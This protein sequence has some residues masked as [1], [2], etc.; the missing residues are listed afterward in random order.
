MNYDPIHIPTG[1]GPWEFACPAV[2]DAVMAA[3]GSW[4]SPQGDHTTILRNA[5]LSAKTL[6]LKL[7]I[8]AGNF[9]VTDSIVRT[10]E[11]F[12]N[13]GV[14]GEA[15]STRLIR[16]IAGQPGN[17][18]LFT[19][20]G[21]LEVDGSSTSS[22]SYYFTTPAV[23]GTDTVQ[24]NT[25][26]NLS[27]GEWL[28]FIDRTQPI[29]H[30][31]LSLSGTRAATF[32][33]KVQIQYVDVP[34]PFLFTIQSSVYDADAGTLTITT[35]LPGIN[36]GIGAKITLVSLSGTGDFDTLEGREFFTVD[37]T[38]GRTTTIVVGDLDAATAVT[39][40]TISYGVPTP[41]T[42][43]VFPKLEA[44]YAGTSTSPNL[45]STIVRRF[46]RSPENVTIDGIIFDYD[47]TA[48]PITTQSCIVWSAL[49][50]PKSR[51]CEFYGVGKGYN[52][53]NGTSDFS[54]SE[55]FFDQGGP[56]QYGISV[57][58][59]S[60]GGRIYDGS[61]AR[62][63][64]LTNTL[65]DVST[66][67]TTCAPSHIQ[68]QNV[69]AYS[70][71]L[72]PFTDHPGVRNLSWINCT[73]TGGAASAFSLRGVDERVIN[74][75]GYGNA[76]GADVS[77][78]VN[79]IIDGGLYV[80]NGVG[81]SILRC[82]NP[83]IINY[84][85]IRDSRKAHI[86]CEMSIP[87]SPFDVAYPGLF[88]EAEVSGVPYLADFVNIQ[89]N[90]NFAPVYG[91]DWRIKIRVA[92]RAPTFMVGRPSPITST[93]SAATYDTVTA[94]ATI[95]SS[96]PVVYRAGDI[97][98]LSAL[99]GTGDYALLNGQFPTRAPTSGNTTTIYAPGLNAL[100]LTGGTISF[101][102]HSPA[103]YPFPLEFAGL[104]SRKYRAFNVVPGLDADYELDTSIAAVPATLPTS[105]VFPNQK[106]TF[107]KPNVGGSTATIV[108]KIGASTNPTLGDAEV[109]KVCDSGLIFPIQ[110]GSYTSG[111]GL[112][113]L[114]MRDAMPWVAADGTMAAGVSVT[115][116]G[117]TG[118]GADLASLNG[119][120]VTVAGGNA[121]SVRVTKTTGLTVTS[122]TGGTVTVSGWTKR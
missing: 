103:F 11:A 104:V 72:S 89:K 16:K 33:Q 117:L 12:S 56:L 108:G 54:I 119:A 34:G 59:G 85:I 71:F 36:Y 42:I 45:N 57:S 46:S 101:G 22:P 110:T 20:D 7:F 43:T 74:C 68:T 63:R 84:P 109:Y 52:I 39:G 73:G 78:A 98:T 67:A 5:W 21:T 48:P 18:A 106:V 88:V 53:T 105:G 26:A 62:G 99:T 76:V 77:A 121:K 51:R 15:G 86:T 93:I 113:S 87:T 92:G 28:M 115:I 61:G 25:L 70:Y 30:Y 31:L 120:A 118:T 66:S 69:Q 112:V 17:F 116:S 2:G 55:F 50:R 64:H 6:G 82:L 35:N 4:S 27:V 40:G 80:G 79:P 29:N 13:C 8:P 3:D 114:N 58:T 14:R 75:R 44:N 10:G 37:P 41:N 96:P 97:V 47:R 32:G 102:T 107:S 60:T 65:A 122:I 100:T 38:S 83:R 94:L 81:I 19:F 9:I 23:Q 95:T 111:S 1:A 49:V 90:A 24:L 91:D